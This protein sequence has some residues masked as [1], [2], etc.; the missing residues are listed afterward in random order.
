M[1]KKD[2][3]VEIRPWSCM[4]DTESTKAGVAHQLLSMHMQQTRNLRAHEDFC[5]AEGWLFWEIYLKELETKL[6]VSLATATKYNWG[7]KES[8]KKWKV[9]IYIYKKRDVRSEIN[10]V[11]CC[12]RQRSFPKAEG[13]IELH[14]ETYWARSAWPGRGF[15]KAMKRGKKSMQFSDLMIWGG[16]AESYTGVLIN[17]KQYSKEVES[18]NIFLWEMCFTVFGRKLI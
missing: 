15:I 17:T 18:I 8:A 11:V 2:L 12:R 3:R 6:Q 5:P 9:Y 10:P 1:A 16:N 13:W 14:W 4:N 7:Q